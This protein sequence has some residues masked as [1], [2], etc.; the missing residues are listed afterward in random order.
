MNKFKY[1]SSFVILYT[2]WLELL[3]NR[4]RGIESLIIKL[5]NGYV[6]SAS[7][8]SP[9]TVVM[10]ETFILKRYTPEFLKISKNDIVVD[11]GAH[12]GDFSIFSCINGASKVIA[13]EPDLTSYEDLCKNIS[14]NKIKCILPVNIAVSDAKGNA[15]FYINENNGGN[16][17]Y[18]IKKDSLKITVK[19]ISLDDI[20]IKFKIKNIDFLK[21]DCEG[22]EGLIIKNTKL[23]TWKNISKI[24]LE[25]H[26][27]VSI[28]DNHKIENKLKKIGYNTKSFELDKDFGYIY[29]WRIQTI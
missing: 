25:Y 15:S 8:H 13:I 2:N 26:N 24:A 12:I 27:N 29:A 22:A 21:I 4:I 19:T 6:I 3:L 5:R 11:I 28:I 23:I 1:W 17:F 14:N 7:P 16:S 18:K 10:D 9:L 20:F